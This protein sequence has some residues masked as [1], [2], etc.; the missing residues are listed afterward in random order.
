MEIKITV[1]NNDSSENYSIESFKKKLSS[2]LL[3]VITNEYHTEFEVQEVTAKKEIV[4]TQNVKL[5]F[6]PGIGEYF[7]LQKQL[8]LVV[9]VERNITEQGKGIIFVKKS[10]KVLQTVSILDMQ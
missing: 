4:F 1:I 5:F 8:Y 3:E 9:G 10:N 7:T 6:P 2:T